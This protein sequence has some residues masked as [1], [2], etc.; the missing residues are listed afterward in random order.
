[1]K[2]IYNESTMLNWSSSHQN[3]S[4]KGGKTQWKTLPPQVGFLYR[5]EVGDPSRV[6]VSLRWELL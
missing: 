6:S 4:P 2:Q 3:A 1:M 5:Y